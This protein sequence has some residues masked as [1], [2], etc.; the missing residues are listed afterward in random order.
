MREFI[1]AQSTGRLWLR[2]EATQEKAESLGRGYSGHPPYVNQTDAEA[3]VA[4]GP[5][6]RGSYRLFGPFNHVR[7]GPVCF[8]LEPAKSN[9][10]FGRSG[11]LIHGDNAMGSQTASH[12]CIILSRAIREKI[13]MLP[14]R[15]LVVV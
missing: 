8:F 1:Y 4:R 7:L 6:P 10:M 11:F 12:G 9:Q 3:L 13:A 15:T 14:V 2:D 5:I